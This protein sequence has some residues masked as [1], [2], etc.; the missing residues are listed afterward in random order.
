MKY[1]FQILILLFVAFLA[2]TAVSCEDESD[3]IRTEP[4]FKVKLINQDS[5]DKLTVRSGE[6]TTRIKAIDAELKT[7]ADAI[8]AG[9]D[10]D[11]STIKAELG[12][13][14]VALEKEK[15][16]VTATIKTVKSGKVQ[17]DKL[18]GD[19]GITEV[20][21]TDSLT[22][23]KFPLNSNTDV[24]RYTLTIAGEPYFLEATYTRETI[25]N[26]RTV[27]VLAHNFKITEHDEKFSAIS[28]WQPDST[29]FSSHEATVT[30][31]F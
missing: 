7:I 31:Y 11:Y 20:V 22:L 1:F 25:F 26:E 27:S 15:T 19:G 23:F 14:K 24:S 30:L 6:I 16:T 17:P 28:I 4:Y 5:L 18:E 13:E 8:A 3:F 21:Y 12:A 29:D 2:M 9:D 10:T